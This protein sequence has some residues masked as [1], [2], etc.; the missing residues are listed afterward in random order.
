MNATLTDL[1]DHQN[2]PP[3]A[4]QPVAAACTNCSGTLVY[5]SI[6]AAANDMP[7]SGYHRTH[8]HTL[9]LEETC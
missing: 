7:G 1:I 3:A 9:L 6:A 2:C 5:C 4:H 8:V